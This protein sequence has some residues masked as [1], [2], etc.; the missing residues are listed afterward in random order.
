MKMVA[1]YRTEFGL[2]HLEEEDG[3]IVRCHWTEKIP[4]EYCDALVPGHGM[5]A[6]ALRQFD[7]Y[8]AGQR[9]EFQFPIKLEGTP[10]QMRVWN[11]L[12]EIPYGSTA[13]YWAIARKIGCERGVRAVAQA[14][15]RN[16]IGIIVP[17]HR[18]IGSDG[19]LTGYAGGLDKKEALLRLEGSLLKI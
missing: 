16:P 4:D 11:T 7:E 1:Y 6:D 9:R 18:I 17:C 8:F 13:S 5:L 12:Q 10:F 2:L 14:C 3:V 15:H 19:S